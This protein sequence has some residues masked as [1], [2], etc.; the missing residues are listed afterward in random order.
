MFIAGDART[1]SRSLSERLP[2]RIMRLEGGVLRPVQAERL[3][4]MRA[5]AATSPSSSECT[6]GG[7][8]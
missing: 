8:N 5:V 2:A 4:M 7:S 3:A 6:R 1:P